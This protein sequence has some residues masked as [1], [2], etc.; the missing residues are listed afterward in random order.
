MAPGASTGSQ[1]TANPPGDTSMEVEEEVQELLL[2]SSSGESTAPGDSQTAVSIDAT[3]GHQRVARTEAKS[4]DPATIWR[5]KPRRS[6]SAGGA[7][8]AT[9]SF[10]FGNNHQQ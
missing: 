3:G 9:L 4:P 10:S 1:V 6:S 7:A 5:P 2:D 8:N